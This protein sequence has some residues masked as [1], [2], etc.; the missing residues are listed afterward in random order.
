M[1]LLHYA[2]SPSKHKDNVSSLLS[3]TEGGGSGWGVVYGVKEKT[4]SF[5]QEV[6]FTDKG[7][8]QEQQEAGTA[9]EEDLALMCRQKI[10][11][12]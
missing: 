6:A 1:F 8:G 12:F 5:G 3:Q 7:A 2:T 10:R 9:T 4:G 11:K